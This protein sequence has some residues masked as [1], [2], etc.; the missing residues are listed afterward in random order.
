MLSVLETQKVEVTKK[1]VRGVIWIPCLSHSH[2]S[3]TIFITFQVMAKIWLTPLL[4][5]WEN[6]GPQLSLRELVYI[7]PL[8]CS[9]VII[10]MMHC[11]GTYFLAH[12]S[13]KKYVMEHSPFIQPMHCCSQ[14]PKFVRNWMKQGSSFSSSTEVSYHCLWGQN[15][16]LLISQIQGNLHGS[17]NIAHFSSVCK[18]VFLFFPADPWI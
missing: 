11:A 2:F 12:V 5:F 14:I 4:E 9:K 17:V 15:L 3:G 8:M 6:F 13:W 18:N 1:G 10:L 7:G 16:G